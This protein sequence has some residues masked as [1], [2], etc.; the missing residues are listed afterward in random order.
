MNYG[1]IVTVTHKKNLNRPTIYYAFFISGV[2]NIILVLG[3]VYLHYFQA[4]SLTSHGAKRVQLPAHSAVLTSSMEVVLKEYMGLSFD[5][6]CQQVYEKAHVEQGFCR[7]D[8]ALA[9]LERVH[10][11]DLARACGQERLE[12]C[13]YAFTPREGEPTIELTLYPGIKGEKLKR[14]QHFLQHEAYPFTPEGLFKKIAFLGN[15]APE[16]LVQNFM[17]SEPFGALHLALSKARMTVPQEVLISLVFEGAWPLFDRYSQLA[18]HQSS[19]FLQEVGPML[20]AYVG[21]GSSMACYLAILLEKEY[22]LKQFDDVL[23][24]QLL[25]TIEAKNPEMKAF[26]KDVIISMRCE[27][28]RTLA[29][30]KLDEKSGSISVVKQEEVETLTHLEHKIA[31]GDTLWG[32]SRRYGVKVE[33]IEEVNGLKSS[34]LIPGKTLKIP[35]P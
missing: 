32:L 8:L 19:A 33:A 4:P 23:L 30:S 12:R 21:S 1:Y 17:M 24:V 20:Q 5:Q 15:K 22:V 34:V 14:V 16:G 25:N 18:M 6:L 9:M 11:V 13:L 27:T 35:N 26:L 31:D 2:L 28:I 29:S 7:A 3:L 10:H